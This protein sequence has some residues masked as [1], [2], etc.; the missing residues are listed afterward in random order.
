MQLIEFKAEHL[1]EMEMAVTM[2]GMSEL[3]EAELLCK[4]LGY[5]GSNSFSAYDGEKIIGCGGVKLLCD[6]I[7][8]GWAIPT[9]HVLKHKRE[10]IQLCLAGL[11]IILETNPELRRIQAVILAGFDA[12]D[13][14]AEILGFQYE[15]L[16]R[17]YG[18]NGE[19]YKMFAL[20][21]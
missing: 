6:G 3:S 11:Q 8:E 14:L 20:V 12:G 17:K 5:E 15:G 21:R 10:I 9:I 16:L 1:L 18:K 19:D 4:G 13:R 2:D 7:G